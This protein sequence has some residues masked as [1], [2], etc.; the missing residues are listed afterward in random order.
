MNVPIQ[1]PLSGFSPS[2]E[3][4]MQTVS[5]LQYCHFYE[6][7]DPL[8]SKKGKIMKDHMSHFKDSLG[9]GRCHNPLAKTQ[10]LGP[11]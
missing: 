2:N 11:T 7:P 5:I 3:M 6:S 8:Q 10:S 1:H 9:N 4:G